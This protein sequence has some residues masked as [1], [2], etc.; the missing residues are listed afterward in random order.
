LPDEL[1]YGGIISINMTKYGGNP[2]IQNMKK[3]VKL[4]QRQGPFDIV[5]L[6]GEATG[7]TYECGLSMLPTRPS[8]KEAR[9]NQASTCAYMF[10]KASLLPLN[11]SLN[12]ELGA[13]RNYAI[14]NSIGGNLASKKGDCTTAANTADYISLRNGAEKTLYPDSAVMTRRLFGTYLTNTTNSPGVSAL[15]NHSSGCY[16]AVQHKQSILKIA[17]LAKA[18]DEVANATKCVIVF[19]AAGTAPKHDSFASYE[20]VKSEMKMESIVFKEENVWSVVFVVAHARLVISTSLHVRIMAFIF[21][22]PRITVCS[23]PKHKFF[24]SYWDKHGSCTSSVGRISYDM[25]DMLNITA[26][27]TEVNIIEEKYLKNFDAWSSL[28]IHR[29]SNQ[30]S[31]KTK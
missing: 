16:I 28:L 10:P 26:N 18:M 23:G 17:D 3:L 7:C 13:P 24:I 1:L 29:G 31:K 30:T 11:V 22:R 20:Q 8:E 4:S 5:Y 21:Q 9:R 12:D 15:L 19:F 14:L 2:N 6:G 27:W 25:N